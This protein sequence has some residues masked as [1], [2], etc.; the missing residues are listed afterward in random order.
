MALVMLDLFAG[1]GGASQAM[2]D[3]GWKV[4]TMDVDPK[5]ET[6]IIADIRDFKWNGGPVDFLWAS[7]PCTE[8]SRESMPWCRTGNEP[9][10]DLLAATVRVISEVNPIWWA[11]ENVR[12]AIKYFT[13]V[14]GKPV[15]R[16]SPVFIWGILPP[17]PEIKI[18]PWK[19]KLSSTQREKRA[20]IPYEISLAIAK[21]I[22]GSLW[23]AIAS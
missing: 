5:F 2:K 21:S 13:R 8:F 1:L 16:Y 15:A 4:I 23:K 20:V 22:E 12:G 10:M 9:S 6:D 7:P 3:R 11:I 19:E 18:K 17:L 14:L